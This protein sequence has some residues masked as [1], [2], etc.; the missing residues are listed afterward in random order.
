MSKKTFADKLAEKQFNSDEIQKSWLVH[1]SAFGPILTPAFVDNYQAKVAVCAALN[2]ISN[3]KL[4][5]G[6]KKI[7]YIKKFV[8]TDADKAL[9]LFMLALVF[10]F[11]GMQEQMISCYS[12]CNSLNHKFYMPYVKVAKLLQNEVLDVAVS[13]YEKAID[14]MKDDELNTGTK[15]ILSS[16]YTNYASALIMK[17]DLDKA[18]EMLDKSIEINPEQIGREATLSIY[19]AATNNKDLAIDTL[20]NI[21]NQQ[22]FVQTKG[23]VMDILEGKHFQ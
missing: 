8:E 6:L 3:R 19:Y 21:D 15:T 4:Q 5:E 23:V 20:N 22:L 11:A 9:V 12:E 13:N 10:E 2:L 1:V 7:E 14:C 18:K 16:I 17:H